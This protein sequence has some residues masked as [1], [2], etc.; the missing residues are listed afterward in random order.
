MPA[1]RPFLPRVLLV[2]DFDGTLASDTTDA[3]LDVYGVSREDWTRDFEEA[4]GQGWDEIIRRGEALIALGRARGEPLSMD[5]LRHAAERV[6]LFEGV[7]E[8]PARLA[9]VAREV[10]DDIE[11]ECIILSSGFAEVIKATPVPDVFSDLFAS[12]FHFDA[13]DR[14]VCVKRIVGHAEKSMYL[15]AIGKGVGV[16]GANEPEAAGRD[17]D[18]YDRRVLFDQMV[19]VGDG[20]SD[21]HA[22]GFMLTNGGIGIAIDKDERFDHAAQQRRDQRVDNL[23]RPDY[24]AGGELM[25]SLEHAVRAAAERIAL[26]ALGQGE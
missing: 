13:D 26:R 2:F 17:V 22:F 19:Y 7:M 5:L 3:V 11:V 14:A 24:T 12:T 9:H 16:D 8:M 6:R 1:T 25:R 18:E 4:L 10:R 21:L 23:A 20:A 15:E